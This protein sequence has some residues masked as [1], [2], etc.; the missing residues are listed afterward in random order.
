MRVLVFGVFDRLHPGHQ[1]FLR[2]ARERGTQLIVAVARDSVVER[3][4]G[5]RPGLDENRR[6]ADLVESGLVDEAHLGDEVPSTYEVIRQVRPDLICLGHD[7]AKLQADLGRW[8]VEH[9]P[10]VKFEVLEPY[11]PEIYKSSK[12]RNDASSSESL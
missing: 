7:Q 2:Q 9:L 4:K 5:R 3:L 1:S 12:M 8:L 11:R 6:A 10:G